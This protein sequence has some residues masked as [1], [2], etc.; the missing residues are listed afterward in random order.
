MHL[1]LGGVGLRVGCM[2]LGVVWRLILNALDS[3]SK[4]VMLLVIV[5]LIDESTL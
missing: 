5:I 3:I 2:L 4:A 1:L